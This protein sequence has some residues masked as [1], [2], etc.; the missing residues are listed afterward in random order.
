MRRI[1]FT[2]SRGATR[3]ISAC[4]RY[5]GGRALQSRRSRKD[6]ALIPRHCVS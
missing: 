1:E 2:M 4:R 6:E 5:C 3:G